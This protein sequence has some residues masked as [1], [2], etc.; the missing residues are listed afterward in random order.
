M[1]RKLVKE[2]VRMQSVIISYMTAC[3]Q[4][5]GKYMLWKLEREKLRYLEQPM[6]GCLPV[7]NYLERKRTMQCSS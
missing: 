4:L 5:A 2:D 6:G 1:V 7:D 3:L